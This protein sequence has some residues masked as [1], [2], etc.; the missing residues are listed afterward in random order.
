MQYQVYYLSG[1]TTTYIN[2]EQEENYTRV[3]DLMQLMHKG[4]CNCPRHAQL[5]FKVPLIRRQLYIE[6]S[7]YRERVHR[8]IF[9]PSV[10]KLIRH[11]QQQKNHVSIR[12]RTAYIYYW[13]Q[14]YHE[15]LSVLHKGSKHPCQHGGDSTPQLWTRLWVSTLLLYWIWLYTHFC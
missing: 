7:I 13:E 4:I 9:G 6:N 2:Y 8:V 10:C 14:K 3:I 15:I 1:F 5:N 12:N 11:R